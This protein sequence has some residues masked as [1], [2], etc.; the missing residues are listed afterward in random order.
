MLLSQ[1][2]YNSLDV[3]VLKNSKISICALSIFEFTNF[4][5]INSYQIYNILFSF[6]REVRV[7]VKSIEIYF[8]NTHSLIL[9]P[10]NM[11]I[12]LNNC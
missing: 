2:H 5:F 6:I 10:I 3:Y 11:I 7:S 8:L 4:R 9:H 12:I 1:I